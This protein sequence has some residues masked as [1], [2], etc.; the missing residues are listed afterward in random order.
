LRA[1][2][3]IRQASRYARLTQFAEGGGV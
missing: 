1:G 2:V 3:E